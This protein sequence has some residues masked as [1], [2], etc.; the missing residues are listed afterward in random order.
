M[1]VA[2]TDHDLPHGESLGLG[3]DYQLKLN[4][5]LRRMLVGHLQPQDWIRVI[6]K[7]KINSQTGES[8][9]KAREVVKLSTQ[10]AIRHVQNVAN[11]SQVRA[12]TQP[13]TGDPQTKPIRV[14]I[15]QKSGC[16]QRGAQRI[17]AAIAQAIRTQPTANTVHLQPTGCMKRCKA[18]PNVVVISPQRSTQPAS[19]TPA[20][21]I[22]TASKPASITKYTQMTPQMVPHIVKK[23][24]EQLMEQPLS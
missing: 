3:S 19:L 13:Q 16:R 22:S 15:C 12:Q 7:V 17:E 20:S 4:G 10:Q 24:M 11:T 2:S 6:G 14:L 21:G 23:V 9:W 8:Q 18:G 1:Q 5:N